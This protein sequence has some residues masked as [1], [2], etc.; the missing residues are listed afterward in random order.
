[1]RIALVA[2]GFVLLATACGVEPTPTAAPPTPSPTPST[3]FSEAKAIA[4]VMSG[5]H[6][7]VPEHSGITDARNPIAQLMTEG[8]FSGLMDA[9][10]RAS[11][12]LVWVVQVE[13]ESHSDGITPVEYRVSTQF[14]FMLIDAETGRRTRITW[15]D[16]SLLPADLTALTPLPIADPTPTAVPTPTPAS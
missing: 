12:R 2:V 10:V 14:T 16:D 6:I 1:M 15:G 8:Q 4:Q 3:S 5:A 7:G 11:D 9:N 13:G